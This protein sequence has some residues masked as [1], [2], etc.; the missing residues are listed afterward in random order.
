M[1]HWDVIIVGSGFGGAVSALRLAEKGYRVLVLEKG[2]RFRPDDFAQSNWNL[3]RFLWNPTLGMRGPFQMT[4]TR[5]VT[6]LSGVGVG[7]GSLVYANTLPVPGPA[8]FT[9]GSWAGLRDWQSELEP[10]YATAKRMLGA[11]RNPTLGVTDRVLEKIAAE[12]GQSDAF[13]ATDVAVYFGDPASESPDPYFGGRGPARRGCNACGACMLGCRHGAKNTLD[14]N[15]LFLAEQ[16]GAVI[17]PETTA[18]VIR[19]DPAGG[20]QVIARPTFGLRRPA[21]TLRA[22]RVVLAGGVLGTNELL[23]R[24]RGEPDGLPNLSDQV[25]RAVRTNSESLI[26]VTAPSGTDLSH[27]VAIGSILHTD[28]HSH[29]EPVRYPAGSGLFRALTLPHAPGA[30]FPQ[31]MAASLR[32]AMANPG[33][34]ARGLLV[35]D[36]GAS[37]AILLYMRTLEG[38][39]RFELGAMGLRSRAGDGDL[40]SADIPEASELADAFARHL[41]GYVVSLFTETLFGIPTTAHILGGAGIGRTA[42]EGVIGEDHQV[43]G[44]PGLYVCDGSAISANPGVNPSLTIT[45]MSERAMSR[46][47]A[48]NEASGP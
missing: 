41:D 17:W 18:E 16:L 13:S 7:G 21:R 14:K 23:L 33:R 3:P 46:V 1:D 38:T 45:A 29:L 31:R 48:A 4:F 20:Y 12:R 43:H 27:G 6:V 42:A 26:G 28:A 15:Y 19:P 9:Q 22:T 35:R 39:L 2:R 10:H 37:T 30:T 40:P 32:Y 44:Y 25:G 11:A 47:P 5:H 34:T 36:F 8:F 24:M